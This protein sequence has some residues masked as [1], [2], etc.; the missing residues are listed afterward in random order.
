MAEWGDIHPEPERDEDGAE[1]GY[2]A[3]EQLRRA[4]EQERHRLAARRFF[5]AAPLFRIGFEADGT[6]S[7]RKK[8]YDYWP[9]RPPAAATRW[10]VLSTHRDLEDAER[11]LRQIT[12]PHIYY[13]ERGRLA[14][15]PEACEEERTAPESPWRS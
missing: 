5:E 8:S 15:A 9:N 1:E 7:L 6:V 14:R 10:R 2:D 3:A 12:S 4:M 13:D 11:R